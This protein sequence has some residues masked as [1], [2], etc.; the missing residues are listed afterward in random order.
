MR[1]YYYH[2]NYVVVLSLNPSP[3]RPTQDKL[4]KMLDF[5]SISPPPASR[6][7]QPPSSSF[8]YVTQTYTPITRRNSNFFSHN[9]AHNKGSPRIYF[10][11][12]T[13]RN[14]YVS[15]PIQR[16]QGYRFRQDLKGY[17]MFGSWLAP[18]IAL[19][20]VFWFEYTR[21]KSAA[22]QISAISN[23]VKVKGSEEQSNSKSIAFQ[24]N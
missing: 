23:S 2:R 14:Y 3:S 12:S 1:Y 4:K 17:A 15:E 16:D 11:K 6:P 9:N 5:G 19:L 22:R 10:D 7:V 18:L 8:T 20:A 13:Q 24:H 21:R